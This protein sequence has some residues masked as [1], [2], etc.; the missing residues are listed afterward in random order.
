VVILNKMKTYK[1]SI[2]DYSRYCRINSQI[3]I[4]WFQ[5]LDA[6]E[7]IYFSAYAIDV[8]GNRYSHQRRLTKISLLKSYN[9]IRNNWN[10]IILCED[11][12]ALHNLLKSHLKQIHGIGDLYI[13][14]TSFRIG[15]F[16]R[17]FPEYI[18]LHAGTKDGAKKMGIETKNRTKLSK[19]ELPKEFKFTKA[20]EIEDILCIYKDYFNSIYRNVRNNINPC[21]QRFLNPSNKC[22]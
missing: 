13:Y 10:K 22:C 15:A 5:S 6:N 18:Y 16:R 9:F 19:S 17:L 4:E 2:S 14:D 11:F 8:Y 12:D 3:E 21:K 7:V 1:T 20:H